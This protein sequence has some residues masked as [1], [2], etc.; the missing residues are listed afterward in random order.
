MSASNL[1]LKSDNAGKRMP[2]VLTC[3]LV[4]VFIFGSYFFT[5]NKKPVK[6][7]TEAKETII[8]ERD[9]IEAANNTLTHEGKL[10]KLDYSE[11]LNPTKP[12]TVLPSFQ[13]LP[14][15]EVTPIPPINA[16]IIVFDNTSVY[17]S[18]WLVPLGSMVKCLL[19]HNIVT[20]NFEAPVIAQ[21]WEDFYFD[22][23]LLLP[24]GT[25]IYGTAFAGKQRDR[26]MVKFDNIVFQDGKT[27][28]V[29]AIGLSKDGSGGITGTVIDESNKQ[30]FIA[31]ALN[32]LGGTALGLQQTGTNAVTGLSQVEASSRNA[33]LNG[34]ASTFQSEA[35]KVKGDA[36]NA[37]GYAIVLAG[38]QLF[39]YF[40]KEADIQGG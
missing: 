40:E 11:V 36:D 18:K 20:N 33:L 4:S 25:R 21:V 3:V 9:I 30:G 2:T 1:F 14:K 23:K 34:V 12:K 27:I 31:M 6:S 28:K 35:Q 29:N 24:F 5:Q 22:G 26:V 19:I 8:K 13:P 39:V 38:N 32:F 15:P 37:K 7:K 16:K 17:Q 10:F